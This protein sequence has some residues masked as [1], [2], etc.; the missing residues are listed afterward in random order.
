MEIQSFSRD[1]E[2]KETSI[3]EE[4]RHL[5][6]SFVGE[7]VTEEY[8]QATIDELAG[9]MVLLDGMILAH[10]RP[11]K[12]VIKPLFLLSKFEKAIIFIDEEGTKHPIKLLTFLA[13]DSNTAH[14]KF[15]AHLSKFLNSEDYNNIIAESLDEESFKYHCKC[16]SKV[17]LK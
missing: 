9:Y 4:I 8:I 2:N 7:Y 16:P 15:L 17:N 10:S 12:G 3:G 6:R 1:N 13:A 5:T 11:E 14:I